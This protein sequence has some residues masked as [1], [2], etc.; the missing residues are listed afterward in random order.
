MPTTNQIKPEKV[1]DYFEKEAATY[2]EQSG[3]AMWQVFRRREERTVLDLLDLQPGEHVL[4]AG[5]GAGYYAEQMVKRGGE[6]VALDMV[7]G[8]LAALEE[9]LQIET[10]LGDLNDLHLEPRFDKIV[11]A[12]ALEFVAD[13]AASLRALTA[14]LK[15]DGPGRI[16]LLTPSPTLIGRVYRRFH[17]GHGFTVNLFTRERLDEMAAH[18]DMRIDTVRRAT[19]NFALCLSR[20]V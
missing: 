9:R 17:R 3:G 16:V 19:F 7:P 13:P 4:D 6:V 11:C 1:R 12:G 20:R 18:A 2:S 15:S 8:M 14:G 5:S 10:T